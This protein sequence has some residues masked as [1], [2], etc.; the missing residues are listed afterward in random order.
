MSKT[1]VGDTGTLIQLDVGQSLAGAISVSIEAQRPDG[2]AV[3]WAGTVVDTTKVQFT[4][5]AGTFNM[6]GNWKL[7]A[8]VVL[9]SGAWLGELA[10]LTVYRPFQ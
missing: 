4:T 7:Q 1:Y 5:L 10:E 3:S 2:T 8:K 9:P 6:G